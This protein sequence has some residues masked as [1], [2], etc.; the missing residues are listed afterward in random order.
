MRTAIL[1][2]WRRLHET[3]IWRYPPDTPPDTLLHHYGRA[4]AVVGFAFW[5]MGLMF[6]GLL[7]FVLSEPGWWRTLWFCVLLCAA[8]CVLISGI[9]SIVAIAWAN[10]T[11]R[12]CVIPDL[13]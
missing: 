11:A 9:P 4:M 12:E 6:S 7:E 3:T 5:S 8:P 1:Q 2:V 10:E 13:V